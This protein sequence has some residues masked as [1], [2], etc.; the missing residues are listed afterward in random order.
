M[1]SDPE[2]K[3]TAGARVTAT[4]EIDQVGAWGRECGLDQVFKQAAEEAIGRL[5]KALGPTNWRVVGNP[6][7]RAIMVDDNDRT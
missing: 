4:V 1:A 2:V 6:R 7:V 5:R 3:V